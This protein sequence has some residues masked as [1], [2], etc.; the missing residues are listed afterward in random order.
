[1]TSRLRSTPANMGV[2]FLNSH[3][4]YDDVTDGTA[5]HDLRRR[6]ARDGTELGWMSG[7]PRHAPQH[8][9]RGQ[10]RAPGPGGSTSRRDDDEE[11]DAE[12][13]KPVAEGDSGSGPARRR[14]SAASIPA[15]RISRSG[16]GPSASSRPRSAAKSFGSWETGPMAS[17][18][19]GIN[20]DALIERPPS[21]TVSQLPD[22]ICPS[23][24]A[25]EVH[26]HANEVYA[27]SARG[28]T[29]IELIVVS[30]DHL[31]AG[32]SDHPGRAR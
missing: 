25:R 7:H 18:S 20:I 23:I 4:R 27:P 30:L 29:L 1:M 31:R 2:F 11:D 5:N 13:A 24:H 6:E 8:G 32:G 17:S 21:L 14:L 16:M 15:G 28:T 19:A 22:I 3:I 10:S 26:D 12:R 9:T